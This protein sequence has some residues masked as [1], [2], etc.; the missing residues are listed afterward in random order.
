[1]YTIREN[2]GSANHSFREVFRRFKRLSR[3]LDKTIARPIP[4][5]FTN[6]V[7]KREFL[8]YLFVA[9]GSSHRGNYAALSRGAAPHR[10]H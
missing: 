6:K 9:V 5:C 2:L 1:M 8:A 7:S 4:L 10:H 3:W